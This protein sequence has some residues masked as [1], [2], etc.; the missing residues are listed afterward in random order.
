LLDISA[1]GHYEAGEATEDGLRELE[2]EL[3]LKANF[4]DL[5]PVGHRVSIAKVDGML[6]RQIADVFFYICDQPLADYHY[7]KEELAGLIAI[8]LEDGLKLFSGEV[9]SIA[10][11]AVG[12]GQD[13]INICTDDF[14][15]TIDNYFFKAMILARR[16]LDG[17]KYLLI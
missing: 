13:T 8:N 15:K 14:L 7:Q 3:G 1:A 11:P 4:D 6:D 17:E 9:N 5:I 10:V 16:C 2:E 12:L